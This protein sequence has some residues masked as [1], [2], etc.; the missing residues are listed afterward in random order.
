MLIEIFDVDHG[1]CAL[2]T[3]DDCQHVLL[4]CGR[5]TLTGLRPSGILQARGIRTLDAL[6]VSHADEDHVC[7]LPELMR[8]VFVRSVITNDSL[9][10]DTLQRIKETTAE[11]VS[12]QVRRR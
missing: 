4:D 9:D 1:F 8:D 5:N 11:G 6:V 2:V 3:A 10:P 7:D 12:A